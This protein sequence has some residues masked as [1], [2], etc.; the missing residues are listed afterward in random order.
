MPCQMSKN[1]LMFAAGL[2]VKKIGDYMV[3]QE[4]RANFGSDFFSSDNLLSF[5]N[6]FFFP[7]QECGLMELLNR[8]IKKKFSLHQS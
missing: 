8:C 3:H 4:H 1:S 2:R 6:Y 5:F 7:N